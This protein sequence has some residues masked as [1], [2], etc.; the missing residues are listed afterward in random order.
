MVRGL[1]LPLKDCNLKHANHFH[2]AL[3]YK[4]SLKTSLVRC[5]WLLGVLYIS[6]PDYFDWVAYRMLSLLRGYYKFT[7]QEIPSWF[8]FINILKSVL[9]GVKAA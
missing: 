5:F 1:K 2:R 4:P 6:T 9:N 7:A 3:R 8:G